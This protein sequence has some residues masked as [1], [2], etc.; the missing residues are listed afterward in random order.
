M[1][2]ILGLDIGIA[3]VGWAAVALDAN[4]EPYKILDLNSRIFEKAEDPQ[5]GDSLAAPR[6][7]ARGSR[8]RTRRRRHRMERLRHLFAREGLL[9]ADKIEEIF[10]VPDDV[11][12]LRAEGLTRCL[13]D[14]EWARVL[15]HIAKHR[16]FKSNRKS[17]ASDAD[18][19]KVIE[20]VRQNA[21]LLKNYKTVGEM[22]F[23][24]EKFQAAKRNKGGSYNFCVSR[25]MLSDEIGALFEAQRKAGNQ[26]ASEKFEDDYHKIFADQRNF[27]DGPDINSH[28]P[29][30]GNQIEN[31]IG[32]CSLE[33]S[34]KRA[35]KASYSFMRF[36]LLQKINHLRLKKAKGEERFLT[37]EE[38]AAV[39]ELAWKTASLTYG[40][41]RKALSL[42]DEWRFTDLYYRWGKTQEEIEKKKLQFT[43]PYHEIRKALD[44]REKGRIQKLTP[45]ALDAIGYIFTVFKNDA[46]IAEALKSAGIGEEDAAA[47]MAAGLTFKGFGHISVK[48]C[49]K[50]IPHLEKGMTY[51]KACKEA[52]YEFQGKSGEKTQ[53][54]SGNLEEIREIPNPVVRRAIAQT[55]KV[56]NAVIRRYGSPVGVN[57]EL[58]REMGRTF[59]ARRDMMKSMEDNSAKNEKL[60]EELKGYGVMHPS[61]L[62]IVKLKLYKDQG[63][64]CAYSLSAMPIEKVFKEHDYAEVDHILPYSR[65]FD[66]SYSNKVLVLTK[67]NRDKGNRTPMEYMANMPGRKHDFI[68]WVNSSI[69]DF[70]KRDNLL[71]ENFDEERED[72]WKERH[73]TDTQYISRFV[74]NLLDEHLEFAPWLSGKK[75]H[76]I[77]VNGAVTD[78]TRKRLGIRKIREDGDLHHAVDAA[79]IA[80]VTQGNIQKLTNYSKRI[81]CAYIKNSDGS[82]TNPD[83][84][85][86][87]KKDELIVQ[88]S[89]HFPEP[90]LKFRHELEARVSDHPKEL[91]ESLKLPSY[92]MEEIDALKPPFVSRMPTRKVRGAAHL[93]TVVSPRLQNEGMI[94]K[95]VTLESLKL[96][97]EKDAIENYYAPE[98]DRLLYEALLH[99]LQA[100]EG[101]GKKAFAE[102]FHKPKADGTPGPAVK[103]VKVAEKSTLSVPVNQGKGLAANG[104]MVR[105]DVF[106]IPEGREHGYYLVPVYTSDVV[107]GELP[108]RAVVAHKSYAEWKIMREEDFLFSLYPNDLIWIENKKGIKVNLPNKLA[109][110]SSLTASR[111]QKE[112][113]FYY[114]GMNIANAQFDVVVH[115]GTYRQESLGVKTLTKMEKW[116]IDVLGGEVNRVSR[117]QRQGFND[118]KRDPHAIK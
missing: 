42:S 22:L 7:K 8:R 65:S 50:L 21:V 112:G 27:D 28:S 52:G 35:P 40:A 24:D 105:V 39:E 9:S 83:T 97:K 47:L 75:Q 34:E 85:E 87:L 93:E 17:A 81:E 94:L 46:K 31:M 72:A 43:V 84:G 13:K 26:H 3:S 96:T 60:K 76:V 66:D 107:R 37:D 58:A 19:G 63:G 114:K 12:S 74:K 20:A 14:G 48:A 103:K 115:D 56:I 38:R 92:S 30:A 45:D 86:I 6:R 95:K 29:Y 25:D 32:N 18:E 106:F 70:R 78:Y 118:M 113:F 5:N 116:T 16:G 109:K 90:W 49:R 77:A 69:R 36:A 108:M 53:F 62:D 67:E 101:N 64:F 104:G 117:E 11:Y 68:T 33:P 10:H 44:K 99:R 15:Y 23:R 110:N 57:V 1:N 71:L 111:V 41:V 79:V 61:G 91:I 89:K 88:M 98:S 82:Y 73:L 2:Y 59:Q 51:D 55:V 54:L 4:D 102:G 100:F 80:T